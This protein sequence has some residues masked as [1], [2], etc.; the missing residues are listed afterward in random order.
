MKSVI[1]WIV[2]ALCLTGCTET[3]DKIDDKKQI[4]QPTINNV[5]T[6]IEDDKALE[7]KNNETHSFPESNQEESIKTDEKIVKMESKNNKQT[8]KQQIDNSK[9]ETNKKETTEEKKS[10]VVKDDDK[11]KEQQKNPEESKPVEPAPAVPKENPASKEEEK[12]EEVVVKAYLSHDTLTYIN[13][14]RE[15]IGLSPLEWDSSLENAVLTRAKETDQNYSHTRPN[16]SKWTTVLP[17][18]DS[19]QLYGEI[20][21]NRINPY[22]AVQAWMNSPSHKESMLDP[23]KTHGVVAVYND[24][25]VCITVKYFD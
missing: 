1:R 23:D 3:M 21:T 22:D 17:N 12:K 9:K 6:I 18:K 13:K 20:I 19:M 24:V 5:E 2:L 16:G 8:N 7:N 10:N 15:K 11:Q 14:E 25:Y 4:D